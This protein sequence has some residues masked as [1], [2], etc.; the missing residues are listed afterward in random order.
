M[1]INHCGLSEAGSRGPRGSDVVLSVRVR[2]AGWRECPRQERSTQL[3]PRDRERCC[4]PRPVHLPSALRAPPRAARTDPLRG[5]SVVRRTETDPPTLIDES[6]TL[7]FFRG[8]SAR[9]RPKAARPSPAAGC[10]C[11]TYDAGRGI[12]ANVHTPSPFFPSRNNDTAP[13]VRVRGVDSCA[14]ARTGGPPHARVNHR[15]PPPL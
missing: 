13:D 11:S 4:A 3:K 14:R 9:G 7:T 8:P 12:H 1:K 15:T 2:R 5:R 10:S 6:I